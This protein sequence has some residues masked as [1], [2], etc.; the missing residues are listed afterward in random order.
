[1]NLASNLDLFTEIS[2]VV[3]AE[4]PDMTLLEKVEISKMAIKE[5]IK[6]GKTLFLMTSFGK[7][8]MCMK[9]ITLQ[10]IK[11]L[12]EADFPMYT[13]Y[14]LN[15]NTGL[16]NPVVNQY[17][18]GEIK[19]L[20]A[21]I[22]Q[23]DLPVSFHMAT[24]NL[25]NSFFANIIGGRNIASMPGMDKKCQQQLKKAPLDKLKTRIRNIA[26]KERGVKKLNT[27]D[28]LDLIGTRF[29]ESAHRNSL[30][31]E[32]QESCV[33]PTLVE[34]GGTSNYLLSPLADFTT[35]D[36]FEFIGHVTSGRL[37]TFSNFEA[38][39][40][41]Y[42]DSEKGECMVNLFLQSKLNKATQ[43]G[44]RTGCFTCNASSSDQSLENMIDEDDG[45]FLWLKPLNDLRN[46]ITDTHWDLTKRS[47]LSR[48]IDEET[49][50]IKLA[51]N[52]YSPSHCLDLLRFALSIDAD[53]QKVNPYNPRFCILPIEH[54]FY[55]NLLWSRYGYFNGYKALEE[56]KNIY[57][58]GA[59]YYPPK[60]E[61]PVKRA[62]IPSPI[63]IPYCDDQYFH[64]MNGFRDVSAA[65]VDAEETTLK[66]ENI[67]FS[68]ET[69]QELS[70]DVEASYD[71]MDY[72][73]DRAV[74][75]AN[76]WNSTA[77]S[78][79][80]T[81]MRFGFVSINKGGHSEWDRMVRIA[82]QHHRHGITPTDMAD[83]VILKNK[84]LKSLGIT[85][86]QKI[87]L[88]NISD[89]PRKTINQWEA[90]HRRNPVYKEQQLAFSI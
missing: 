9:A 78:S 31:S 68:P 35:F 73:F 64:F 11:E 88:I 3:E 79:I 5:Q 86:D 81:F 74:E 75:N 56:Y 72:E 89:L 23:H 8:S 13:T 39:T 57:E 85:D 2:G 17:A 30:M 49:G 21:Y 32:R 6:H 29:D 71:F 50:S 38:L 82:Q 80:F 63:S 41:V 24:P 40:Q 87:D 54:I 36:V 1:M 44:S 34:I 46:Y 53:E 10:A 66:G 37:E 18:K 77:T 15:S 83:P 4:A 51:P 60:V 22:K 26:A 16:E 42:R 25:S 7:D 33:V 20:K 43:C 47:W 45:R 12:K 90:D 27:E 48:S 55:I 76:S 59:R 67:F 61:N 58:N 28:F 14:I 69:E 19:K 70:I 65:A 62:P 84:I 52:T